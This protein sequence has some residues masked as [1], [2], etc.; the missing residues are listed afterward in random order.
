[1][2]RP[3]DAGIAAWGTELPS[4][5]LLRPSVLSPHTQVAEAAA[6]RTLGA[7]RMAH[8]LEPLALVVLGVDILALALVA[9]LDRTP[10]IWLPVRTGGL[11]VQG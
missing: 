1:M 10:G 8:V 3:V 5:C 4:I 11:G 2:D 9:S 7:E 6:G